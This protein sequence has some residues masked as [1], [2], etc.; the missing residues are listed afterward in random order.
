MSPKS[1]R[2]DGAR[3]VA[4]G[5]LSSK[6]FGVV[7]EVM[8]ARFFGVSPH[9]DVFKVATRAPNLLQNLLGEQTLSASFIPV[10][11]RMLEEG[12]REEAGRFAGAIFGLMLAVVSLLVLLGVLLAPWIVAVL[13]AGFL[14]DG[15]RVA[16]G[17]ITVDRYALTVRAV[18]WVFPMA[19][20]LVMASWCLGILNSHRRFL[21]PYMAPIG[22]NICI[23]TAWVWAA[24]S[25]G[26]FATPELAG[27]EELDRWLFAGFWGALLGGF[28]Q[29]AVQLPA[30]LRE[31]RG[32]SLSFSTRVEGVGEAL[33]MVG[34]AMAGRGVVQLSF[35]LSLFLANFLAEGA[36]SAIGFAAVLYGLPLSAFGISIAAAELPEMSRLEGKTAHAE[37]ASRVH[38]ALAQSAFVV[39][40]A[41]VGFLVFGYLVAGLIYRSGSFGLEDNL[42][43]YA[44]LAAYSLGLLASTI[45]RLL[46]NSFFA[47][48][49]TRTPAQVALARLVVEGSVG[50]ILMIF[51]DLYSVA[52]VFRLST[53][54]KALYLGAVGL[55]VGAS[56]G[57]WAEFFFLRR[58]LGRR[59]GS[60][61]LLPLDAIGRRFVL[62]LVSAAV[63]L[64]V[65]WSAQHLGLRLQALLVLPTYM[66][67]YLGW[68]WWQE[69]EDLAKWAG[70]WLRKR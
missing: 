24:S 11:S 12:R 43:V 25:S 55:A 68:A 51:L 52:E 49:D 36:P 32:L 33:R 15:A 41:V 29:F 57:S 22:W 64:G 62:A 67:V 37:I 61:A 40:P 26:Y 63:G 27:V 69:D 23:V 56:L 58:A 3:T 28:L 5:I 9:A 54:Q 14:D 38:R 46:Q 70:R 7:R 30:V 19:G 16:A 1:S 21:L 45:S 39:C 2:T 42:L 31:T 10:Y 17:E 50:A 34:P 44:V 35:Y 65:W 13:A 4:L 6:V 18:R 59:L 8:L 60:V 20:F 47:L 66:A 53:P 48:R